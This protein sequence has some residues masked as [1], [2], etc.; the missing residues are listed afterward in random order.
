MAVTARVPTMTSTSPQIFLSGSLRPEVIAAGS[1]TVAAAVRLGFSPVLGDN[2]PLLIFTLPV[3]AS[4]VWAGGRG[5]VVA[6][7]LGGLVA[8][9]LFVPPI[10]SFAIPNTADSAALALYLVTGLLMTSLISRGEASRRELVNARTRA[11][12]ANRAKDEFLAVLSHELRT[13]LNVIL[14]HAR[15]LRMRH[16][17]PER[18]TSAAEVIERN[19][20]HLTR[21]VED[22]LD[23][24][25]IERGQLRLETM[26]F[27]LAPLVGSVMNSLEPSAAAKRLHVKASVPSVDLEGDPARLQQ[28]LW[29]LLSNAV[30][31]TPEAGRIR[32][33]AAALDGTVE[34]KVENSD[35]P[36]PSSFLPRMFEPFQQADMTSTRRHSGVGLGLWVVKNIVDLHHGTV[37]VDSNTEHTIFIVR[38]PKR[39]PREQGQGLKTSMAN[40]DAPINESGQSVPLL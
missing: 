4:A 2:A 29:N 17:V 22:L 16:P 12:D 14:G 20:V 15:M 40:L 27:D 21:L 38:L 5:G 18:T 10:G 28:V 11:E 35:A 25:R 24:Q 13:P 23:V 19:G 7:L 36:I 30:K 6:T 8:K 3:I 33:A 34:I 31:F 32:V 1:V 9:F 26:T 37:R 39:Q